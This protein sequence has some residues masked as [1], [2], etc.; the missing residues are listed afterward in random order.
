[1]HLYKGANKEGIFVKATNK[2]KSQIFCHTLIQS[3]Q[4][5]QSKSFGA[6]IYRHKLNKHLYKGAVKKGIFTKVTNKYESLIRSRLNKSQKQIKDKYSVILSANLINP[7]HLN[8]LV[9]L[10]TCT[11]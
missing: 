6:N 11:N 7:S 8:H 3:N 4:P 9:Q 1:M 2:F 10:Y 5:F